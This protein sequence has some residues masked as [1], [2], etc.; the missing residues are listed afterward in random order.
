M[1]VGRFLRELPRAVED[2]SRFAD[3]LEDVP[4]LAEP[5]NLALLNVAVRCLGPGEHYVEAGTF[6]GT[7]LISAALGND[8]APLVAI[9]NW[10]MGDGGREQ[11]DANLTRYGVTATIL[12]GDV[13]DVLRAGIPSPVGVYYYDAGHSYEQQ[14]AGLRLA[15]R[16]LA[17]PSVV[18]VDDTDWERV[19]RAIDDYLAQQPRATEIFRADGNAAGHPEW[20]EGVRVLRWD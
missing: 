5:N 6:R 4:G 14:L 7:S 9:D 13:F 2:V 19:E 16:Y 20:Y 3:L 10:S 15:E 18:I 11:L 12:E 1:D 8:G 17:S